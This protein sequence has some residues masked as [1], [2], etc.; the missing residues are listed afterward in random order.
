MEL[1]FSLAE[2]PILLERIHKLADFCQETL[3][4]KETGGKFKTSFNNTEQYPVKTDEKT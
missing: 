3:W 4:V 1:S 2:L